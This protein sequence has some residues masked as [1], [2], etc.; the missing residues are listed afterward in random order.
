[1]IPK[2][3]VIYDG[4]NVVAIFQKA[5]ATN[6]DSVLM[7][8]ALSTSATTVFTT[9]Q[10]TAYGT[11]KPYSI[12]SD[13]GTGF[14]ISGNAEVASGGTTTTYGLFFYKMDSTGSTLWEFMPPFTTSSSD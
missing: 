7:K 9:K 14:L 1:M 8:V 2:S 12:I 11:V 5:G 13:G 10:N 6:T 4:T 3:S